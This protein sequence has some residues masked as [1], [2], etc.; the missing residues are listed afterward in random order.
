VIKIEGFEVQSAYLKI[1]RIRHTYELL[2]PL[3]KLG[4]CSSAVA[5]KCRQ[6][7]MCQHI[8]M[9]RQKEYCE[10]EEESNLAYSGMSAGFTF[11]GQVQAKFA[12][13]VG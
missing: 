1:E 8:K 6:R 12:V 5:E 4:D 3:N 11:L 9:C 7:A 13:L 10:V 2:H